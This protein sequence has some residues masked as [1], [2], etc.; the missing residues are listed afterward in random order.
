MRD[1]IFHRPIFDNY[2]VIETKRLCNNKIHAPSEIS[3]FQLARETVFHSL[4]FSLKRTVFPRSAALCRH[5]KKNRDFGLIETYQ[6]ENV[7]INKKN[8]PFSVRSSLWWK[9][10][11]SNHRSHRRQ[12]YSLEQPR[13]IPEV[14]G[15]VPLLF[16]CFLD[17]Y[18]SEVDALYSN[19]FA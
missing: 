10:V 12:I 11:D 4:N 17:K 19:I 14:F 15:V 2:I 8:A 7:S 5:F 16:P 3:L 1:I 6:R 18:H 13:R 9:V